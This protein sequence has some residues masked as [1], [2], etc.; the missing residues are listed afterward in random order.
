MWQMLWHPVVFSDR[1]NLS[2]EWKG[3]KT[4]VSCIKQQ[5]KQKLWLS[6]VMLNYVNIAAGFAGNREDGIHQVLCLWANEFDLL[7]CFGL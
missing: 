7:A 3:L 4:S 1:V 2:Q 5:A 6:F